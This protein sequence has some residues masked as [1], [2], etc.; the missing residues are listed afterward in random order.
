MTA[1]LSR[2][3]LMAGAVGLGLAARDAAA[4]PAQIPSWRTEFREVAP[5]VWAYVQAGGPDV[6]YSGIS[7]AGVVVGRDGLTVIDSL[8]APIQSQAFAAA[9]ATAL[10]G[11]S[12]KRL[13]YSHHH[14]DHID[15]AP[16]FPG[17]ELV[18]TKFAREAILAMAPLPPWERRA[19]WAQGGEPHPRIPPTTIIEGDVTYDLG[20]GLTVKAMP[21]VAH[22]AGDLIVYI[23]ERQTVFM[24]DNGFFYVAPYAHWA[25]IDGWIRLCDQLLD[26][27]IR[28]VVPGHGPVGGKRELAEMRDYL[29]TFR[30]EARARYDAGMTP[31]RAAASITLGGR[32]DNWRGAR[33]RL[34]WNTARAFQDFAGG[35]KPEM[36]TAAAA[37]A[38]NEYAAIT[39]YMPQP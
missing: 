37:A 39:G 19:G 16:Y 21:V 22:T 2:R 34:A 36:D 15:G 26:L 27:P 4:A 8:P 13:I 10:P 11:R 6:P 35:M 9:I 25:Y 33:D 7:N 23:P 3:D 17:V 24:G 30:G 31:G 29:V 38:A 14:G 12:V 32:F 28:V 20:D 1:L 18:G 5:G